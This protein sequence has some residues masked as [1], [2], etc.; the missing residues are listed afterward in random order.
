M[1]KAAT[2]TIGLFISLA[3]V[4]LA[5]A[6][7]PGQVAINEGIRRQH[8]QMAL[9]DTLTRAQAAE[10]RHNLTEAATRYDDAWVLVQSIGTG[11]D[12]ERDQTRAGLARVRLE[13][14]RNDQ[15]AGHLRDAD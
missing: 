8:S 1:I 7:E 6:Q 3:T 14:A 13:L 11:V 12:E 4:D 15:K 10:A 9:R 5:L 2:L